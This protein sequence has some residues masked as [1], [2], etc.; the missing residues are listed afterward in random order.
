MSRL[1]LGVL[2][3]A[4]A[5]VVACG[6]G[7]TANGPDLDVPTAGT[8]PAL[9]VGTLFPLTIRGAQFRPRERVTVTVA[10]ERTLRKSV[11][12][13]RS[14]RFAVSFTIRLPRCGAVLVRARGT[15]GSRASYEVPR[16][17]CRRP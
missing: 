15:Q 1:S 7:A 9:T 3:L 10:G 8:K 11:Q 6:S 4:A 17:D 2:A 16:P 14:G 13:S 12:A 5:I